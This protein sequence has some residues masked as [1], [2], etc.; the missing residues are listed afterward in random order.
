MKVIYS[1]IVC[2][3]ALGGKAQEVSTPVGSTARAGDR[4]RAV[5]AAGSITNTVESNPILGGVYLRSDW[6]AS[7]NPFRFE[8]QEAVAE[9]SD[10]NE[11]M[12]LIGLSKM[13]DEEGI[14]RT[15]TFVVK[16]SETRAPEAETKGKKNENKTLQETYV[17]QAF[18]EIL[19]ESTTPTEE[20]AEKSS[21]MLTSEQLWFIGAV[22]ISNKTSAVFWPVGSYPVKEESLRQFELTDHLLNDLPDRKT[23]AGE[24][25]GGE[26]DVNVLARINKAKLAKELQSNLQKKTDEL[27]A[28]KKVP[29]LSS[30]PQAPELPPSAQS[31]G[32]MNSPKP[33]QS[34]NVE[35]D[36]KKALQDP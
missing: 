2:L 13:P 17:L 4:P 36:V 15:Y 25:I 9:L 28:G 34:G 18:P 8:V 21:I 22:S 27:N 29:R 33:L 35:K 7:K 11:Q 1:I 19:D 31:S 23:K 30:P 12:E 6:H 32:Q 24:K 14:I 16:T 20:Q 10:R 26:S 3:A 5:P